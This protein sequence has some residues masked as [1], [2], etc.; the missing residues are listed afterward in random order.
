[1]PGAA[2]RRRCV[3]TLTLQEPPRRVGG[4]SYDPDVQCVAFLRNVNQ[5]QR[6][7]PSTD[8]V[9]ASFLLAGA[10]DVRTFQSNGT[11]LFDST[12]ADGV[13]SDA[14]HALAVRSG[15]ERDGFWMPWAE[16]VDIV[17]RHATRSDA[18]RCELTLHDG[19][20]IDLEDAETSRTAAH[21]RCRIVEA[22][23]GWI[24]T[25]N[26]RDAESNA[27]PVA[28]RLTGGPATSRGLPT[29][30]RLVERERAAG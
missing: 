2:R 11:V 14:L 7:H 5:G 24:V 21:R 3:S 8:D 22:G 1:M 16:V 4:A 29:L 19:G 28:E 15:A 30:V 18:R 20:V 9:V 6:G 25:T 17:G 26:E 12:D 13:V 10:H 27:T 23:A